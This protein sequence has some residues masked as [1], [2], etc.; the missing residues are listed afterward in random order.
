MV[1]LSLTTVA[2]I[3]RILSLKSGREERFHV[4]LAAGMLVGLK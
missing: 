4:K 1:E 3:R 2:G